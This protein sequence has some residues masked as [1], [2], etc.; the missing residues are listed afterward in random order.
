MGSN[1]LSHLQPSLVPQ[2]SDINVTISVRKQ[3]TMCITTHTRHSWMSG[4]PELVPLQPDCWRWHHIVHSFCPVCFRVVASKIPACFIL[5]CHVTETSFLSCVSRY[6]CMQLGD[7]MVIFL[8][9]LNEASFKLIL[10]KIEMKWDFF[11]S[12]CRVLVNDLLVGV[13]DDWNP[14]LKMNFR[15]TF[16]TNVKL[17][18]EQVSRRL[19]GVGRRVALNPLDLCYAH[20]DVTP[21]ARHYPTDVRPFTQLE[22]QRRGARQ[23]GRAQQRVDSG[24]CPP[25][26]PLLLLLLFDRRKFYQGPPLHQAAP[27]PFVNLHSRRKTFRRQ[28]IAPCPPKVTF[29]Y[30]SEHQD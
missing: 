20:W 25:P 12:F 17:E 10:K 29:F 14:S 28:I 7:N 6:G 1:A 16:V 8:F 26:A 11:F 15:S 23:G 27:C 24:A 21:L 4:S 3:Y 19:G 9:I 22:A 30:T 18:E 13:N 5:V 2:T